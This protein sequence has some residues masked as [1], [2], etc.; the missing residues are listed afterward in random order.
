MFGHVGLDKDRRF[1]RIDAGREIDAGEVERFLPQ[2]FRVLRQRDR[3]EVDDAVKAFVF[4]LQG[5]PVF[6]CSEIISDVKLPG[7][8][9]AAENAFFHRLD[10]QQI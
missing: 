9:G 5:D 10:G 2:H 8:L 1:F 3:V 4:V 7:R 6:Q